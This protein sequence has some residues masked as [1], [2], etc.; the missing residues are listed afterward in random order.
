MHSPHNLTLHHQL[1]EFAN[2]NLRD[3]SEHGQG[4]VQIGREF[5]SHVFAFEAHQ[6]GKKREP[7]EAGKGA[8]QALEYARCGNCAAKIHLVGP[9]PNAVI[10]MPDKAHAVHGLFVPRFRRG[11]QSIGSLADD[12][13]RRLRGG[14]DP[15]ESADV[16]QLRVKRE[17]VVTQPRIYSRSYA[18][19]RYVGPVI[20]RFAELAPAANSEYMAPRFI[21]RSHQLAPLRHL[22]N[23]AVALGAGKRSGCIGVDVCVQSFGGR[24][25]A[26]L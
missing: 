24:L 20:T 21:A 3:F 16:R 10:A 5:E 15:S 8:A 11:W 17:P 25:S 22:L 19:V 26:A 18:E 13:G 6:L 23:R 9:P 4:L 14:L 1:N 2:V 7:A 12:L